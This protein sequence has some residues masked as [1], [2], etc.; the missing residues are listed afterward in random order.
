MDA[1]AVV[2]L[3][4]ESVKLAILIG[5]PVLLTGVLVVLI[6]GVLQA[7]TQIQDQTVSFVIKISSMLVVFAAFLPWILGK[8]VEYSRNLWE[9]IPELTTMFIQ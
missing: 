9:N 7:A 4:R 1:D 6:V 3:A 8:L 2:T 5:T